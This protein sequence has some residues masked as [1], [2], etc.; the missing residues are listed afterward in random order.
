MSDH[1]LAKSTRHFS[2]WM[3][4]QTQTE[5]N[6]NKG[7]KQNAVDAADQLWGLSCTIFFLKIRIIPSLVQRGR[8]DTMVLFGCDLG[9]EG[10]LLN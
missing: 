9:V 10:Y 3:E 7:K 5:C 4:M 6:E 2:H 1:H 8:C